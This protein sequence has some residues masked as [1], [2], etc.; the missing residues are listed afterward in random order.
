MDS[1]ISSYSQKFS[2]VAITL[3]TGDSCEV[4]VDIVA[5]FGMQSRLML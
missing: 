5:I 3:S 4:S 1:I 2:I